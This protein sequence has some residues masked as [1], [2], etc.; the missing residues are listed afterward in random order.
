[1]K[2]KGGATRLEL[3]R[4]RR[5]L[6][7]VRKASGVLRRKREA[8]IAELFRLARP[9]ADTRQR[10][11]DE[12]QRAYEALVPALAVHGRAGL[13]GM[14][15]P[16]RPIAVEVEAVQ[17]WGVRASTVK[18]HGTVRR[19]LAARGTAPGLVGPATAVAAGRFEGVVD[20]LLEAASQEMLIRR[21]SEALLATSRQV[22]TLERRLEPLVRRRIGNVERA[23]EEREREDRV[24][25]KIL[26]RA[27][28]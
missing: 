19:T 10:I 9:A 26:L 25:L 22:N 20:L 18:T 17:V 14:G 13:R 28:G 2:E 5:Q 21:L 24:R 3:G 8:L 15:W 6:A 11:A 1:M 27:R 23:L 4:A 16:L 12:T 7:R